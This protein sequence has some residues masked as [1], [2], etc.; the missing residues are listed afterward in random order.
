MELLLRKYFWV[1]NLLVILVC[2]YLAARGTTRLI[3]AS[4]PAPPPRALPMESNVEPTLSGPPAREI[5]PIVARNVFCST[6][7]PAPEVAAKEKADD[8]KEPANNEPVKT[9]LNL[10]LIATMVSEQ[11]KAW[12]FA[13]IYDVTEKKTRMYPI[14][15][16]VPGDATVVD[17]LDRRVMLL[18][19]NRNE[20]LDLEMGGA[21]DTAVASSETPRPAMPSMGAG[22]SDGFEGAVKKLGE[23]KW[24]IQR[25]ALNRVLTN[26]TLL[27]RS[28][29]IVPSVQDGKP[30]GFKLYAIRPGSV[31]SLIGLENGDTIHAVNGHAMN[32]PDQALE[33]YTRVRNASHL[34]ISFSRRG[35]TT[36]QDYTIR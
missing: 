32:T 8:A 36:T 31:Y 25:A 30:N 26:T 21:G 16:K 34:S 23:G 24:E 17:I 4:L 11:D 35:K 19:G 20:F 3:G 7:E 9:S 28:A 15:G 5:K 6:C 2:A 29:R 18:N 13:A 12:S 27:A 22:M 1:F 33:V 14:A 10:K